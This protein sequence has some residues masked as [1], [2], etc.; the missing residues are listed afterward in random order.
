MKP[1]REELEARWRILQVRGQELD[2]RQAGLASTLSTVEDKIGK[3]AM[4]QLKQD[5]AEHEQDLLELRQMMTED[6]GF[7]K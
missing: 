6:G 7:T 3:R 5:R 4:V 2:E 1:T